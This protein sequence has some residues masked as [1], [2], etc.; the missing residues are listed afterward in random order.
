VPE[1][2]LDD[3]SKV[4]EH[5]FRSGRCRDVKWILIHEVLRLQLHLYQISPASK[6]VREKIPEMLRGM[7]FHTGFCSTEVE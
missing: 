6:S 3:K 4:S 1:F 7:I 2:N 5:H